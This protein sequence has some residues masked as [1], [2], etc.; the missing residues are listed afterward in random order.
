MPALTTITLNDRETTPVAHVFTPA[1]APSGVAKFVR[2]APS[3]VP[4]GAEVLTASL[5]RANEKIRGKLV[6]SLPVV[7]TQTIN[8]VSDPVV[9]RPA[10]VEI[11]FT[12]SEKSTQ[13]ERKNAIGLAYNAMASGQTALNSFFTDLEEFF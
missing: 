9:V 2:S 6:L 12:F 4:L 3:G 7:A 10:F 5:R 13:Q 1:A 8:G 11:N